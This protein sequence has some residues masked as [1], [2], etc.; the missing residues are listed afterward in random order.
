[1]LSYKLW[2]DKVCVGFE[3]ELIKE[4]QDE[5]TVNNSRNLG[6]EGTEVGGEKED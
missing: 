4:T 1:M 3:E 6:G 2:T 5:R